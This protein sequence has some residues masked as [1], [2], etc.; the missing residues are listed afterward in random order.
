[1]LLKYI[2]LVISDAL[3][4]GY[5][6]ILFF[7]ILLLGGFP[8]RVLAQNDSNN[9]L[10][11]RNNGYGIS[12]MTGTK[13]RL[14]GGIPVFENEPDI[15][16]AP[17]TH[18]ST[19]DF[20]TMRGNVKV[21]YRINKKDSV[22]SFFLMTDGLQSRIGKDFMGIFFNAI[23]GFKRG[24]FFLRYNSDKAT[25]KFV[26]INNLMNLKANNIQFF[27]W[28]YADGNYGAAIPLSGA[29]YQ[30][31]LGQNGGYFGCKSRSHANNRHPTKIPQICVGFGNNPKKIFARL[32]KEALQV[33]GRKSAIQNM[34]KI[35]QEINKS[36]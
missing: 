28:Q 24:T 11:V 12:V 25:N 14:S 13:V 35:S 19:F 9:N 6:L 15:E 1:M 23:P 7:G 16:S 18:D 36:E 17:F 3:M 21:I 26:R 33:M 4:I 29:G 5:K 34:K 22:V 2:R 10:I 30:T 32:Y 20:H 8:T 31:T 27:Y